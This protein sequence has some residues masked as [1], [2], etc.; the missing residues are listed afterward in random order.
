[1]RVP[2]IGADAIS[3]STFQHRL[4]F[5]VTP[6]EF[7]VVEQEIL[8]LR[9]QDTQTIRRELTA[10]W[11]G[12]RDM[13]LGKRIWQLGMGGFVDGVVLTVGIFGLRHCDASIC[14]SNELTIYP[15][16]R[17]QGHTVYFPLRLTTELKTIKSVE[18]DVAA[19]LHHGDG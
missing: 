11:K 15:G 12:I 10:L 13:S 9:G 6:I 8:A 14:P 3:A 18:M 17:L 19:G 2:G 4:P 7:G 16:L 5:L 1:M